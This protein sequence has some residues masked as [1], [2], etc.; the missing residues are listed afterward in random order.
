MSCMYISNKSK[1]IENEVRYGKTVKAIIT[2]RR[3]WTWRKLSFHFISTLRFVGF[4]MAMKKIE[5][6]TWMYGKMK[7]IS[8]VDQDI[9]RV[10][11]AN[12]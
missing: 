11:K 10:S 3:S 9:S 7:C 1:Q 12:E 8:S 4:Y 5:N 2:F 6:N